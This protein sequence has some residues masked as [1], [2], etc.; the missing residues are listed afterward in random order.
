[1]K[2]LEIQVCVGAEWQRVRRLQ[3]TTTYEPPGGGAWEE[4]LSDELERFLVD[5]AVR[6]VW[7]ETDREPD[8]ILFG[9]G[10][11]GPFRLRPVG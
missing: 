10:G 11:A 9:P 6:S 7:V 8:G 2:L 3:G 5:N 1:M 4:H